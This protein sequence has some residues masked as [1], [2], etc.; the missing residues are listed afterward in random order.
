MTPQHPRWEEFCDRLD[1]SVVLTG[2]HG[3]GHPAGHDGA[4]A[5]LASMPDV[6]VAASLAYFSEQGGHC[7]C[8]ILL[9]V[10]AAVEAG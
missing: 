4:R 8:E 3:C 10:A 6:D 5:I 7:D 2:C 1:A 9:N